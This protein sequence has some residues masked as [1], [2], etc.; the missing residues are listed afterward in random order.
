MKNPYPRSSLQAWVQCQSPCTAELELSR[1]IA[2]K[3]LCPTGPQPGPYAGRVVV[4]T[5][6]APHTSPCHSNRRDGWRVGV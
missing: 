2:S 1:L 3:F 5:V 6:A 4:K